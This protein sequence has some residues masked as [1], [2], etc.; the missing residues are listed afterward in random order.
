MPQELG[1]GGSSIKELQFLKSQISK[2][3]SSYILAKDKPIFS[4]DIDKLQCQ[5]EHFADVSSCGLSS[6]Q[7]NTNALLDITATTPLYR[8][9]FPDDKEEVYRPILFPH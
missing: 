1:C 3:S 9:Q 5:A 7:L 8:E 6:C 4:S 2:P